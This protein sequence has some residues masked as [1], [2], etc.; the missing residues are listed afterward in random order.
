MSKSNDLNMTNLVCPMPTRKHDEIMLA[1]GS[2]GSYMY[3]LLN[4]TILPEIGNVKD[5]DSHDA[6]VLNVNGVKLAFTTDS[7]VVNPLFFPGGD[8]GSL[9]VY[10]TVNDL[11]MSG[12]KPLYISLAAIIEEGFKIESI[13]KILSSIHKAAKA[14]G[15][16]VVTGDTKVVEH[17][18]GDGIYINTSG[19]G[20]LNHGLNICPKAVQA[21]DAVIVNGDIGRHGIA[22]MTVREGLQ[23]ESAIR[24]DSAPVSHI[25]ESLLK[26]NINVHCL[27]DITRGGLATTLNEIALQAKV[28]IALDRAQIPVQEVVHSACELLG[29]DVLHVACEGRFVAFV[30]QDEADKALEVMRACTNGEGSKVI[31]VTSSMNSASARPRVSVTSCAGV[32]RIVDMLSGEQLPRIC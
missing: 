9:S 28:D 3:D 5:E 18:K 14:V 16:K 10:G 13:K 29:L 22:I 17:G 7:F 23:F 12:A 21:Q 1:H 15:I 8:I 6:A 2:G 4:N 20:I 26:E 19:I 31:G 27:R 24:S 25:V 11:A 32:R 30:P